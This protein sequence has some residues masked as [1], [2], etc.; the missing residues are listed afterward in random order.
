MIWIIDLNESQKA[1]SHDSLF[2][3]CAQTV[4]QEQHV[5]QNLIRL[6]VDWWRFKNNASISWCPAITFSVIGQLSDLPLNWMSLNALKQCVLFLSGPWLFK[7][8]LTETL[9]RPEELQLLAASNP[10][11][12]LNHWRAIRLSLHENVLSTSS[13]QGKKKLGEKD[14]QYPKYNSSKYVLKNLNA[15]LWALRPLLHRCDLTVC[16]SDESFA[17]RHYYTAIVWSRFLTIFSLLPSAEL[18]FTSDLST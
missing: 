7:P 8:C 6:V 15:H 11:H 10:H 13:L 12:L 1:S 18:V 5:K 14:M 16:D 2:H 9:K 4:K 17:H 3:V